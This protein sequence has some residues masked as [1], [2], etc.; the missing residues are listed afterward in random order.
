MGK[1]GLLSPLSSLLSPYPFPL[2]LPPFFPLC[3]LPRSPSL[4]N[5]SNLASSNSPAVRNKSSF[6]DSVFNFIMEVKSCK[7]NGSY[8]CTWFEGGK[9][10]AEDVE[11]RKS[12]SLVKSHLDWFV[13]R[14]LELLQI[15]VTSF[16]TRRAKEVSKFAASCGWVLR[17]TVWPES[18]GHFYLHVPVGPNQQGWISFANTIKDFLSV[19]TS[20]E[21]EKKSK[22]SPFSSPLSVADFFIRLF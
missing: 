11:N 8:C 15:Q 6:V 3:L 5:H 9:Y 14:I 7:V 20:K 4:P 10:F 18:G 12:L 21:D 17:C 1:K 2:F 22:F 13:D 16:F 19:S